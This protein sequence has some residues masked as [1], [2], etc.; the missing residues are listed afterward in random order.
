MATLFY[1]TFLTQLIIKL[2]ESNHSKDN[3]VKCHLTDLI[4]NYDLILG[5]DI[6]HKLGITFNFENKT[7]T[8][9][10]VLI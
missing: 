10:E 1:T 8:W 4:L 6:L 2:L 9:Q 5:R 3:Y 7:I